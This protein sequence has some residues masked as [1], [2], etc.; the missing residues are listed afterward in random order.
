MA[1]QLKSQR[2]LYIT[3]IQ[4]ILAIAVDQ[5]LRHRSGTISTSFQDTDMALYPKFKSY[6][7]FPAIAPFKAT[8]LWPLSDAWRDS[9]STTAPTSPPTP[10][11]SWLW[12]STTRCS[13]STSASTRRSRRS[14]APRK[15]SPT[16]MR[17]SASWE[18]PKLGTSAASSL[19]PTCTDLNR[20]G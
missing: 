3:S 2:W 13:A 16:S 15:L 12:R 5:K 14:W 10:R 6:R 7:L 17:R 4:L 1:N 9:P 20:T 19:R 11:L 18:D 8:T